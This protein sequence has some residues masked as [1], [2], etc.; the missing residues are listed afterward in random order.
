MRLPAPL[1]AALAAGLVATTTLANEPLGQASEALLEFHAESGLAVTVDSL[2]RLEAAG[3]SYQP[4]LTAPLQGL[5]EC[6][7]ATG[8]GL[9]AGV[10]R[11]DQA[12]AGVFGRT[13]D[14]LAA[15]EAIDEISRRHPAGGALDQVPP[16]DPALLRQFL[17]APQDPA[18]REALLGAVDART[19]EIYRS[20]ATDRALMA[21]EVD[22]LYGFLVEGL[23]LTLSLA[24]QERPTPLLQ[25]V[26]GVKAGGLA[27]LQ[28][29]FQAI[30]NDP[31]LADMVEL[32]NRD[33]L[34]HEVS[35]RVL[36]GR[37]A[38]SERDMAALLER[39]APVRAGWVAP[40]DDG[41]VG[42]R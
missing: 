11:F 30:R 12:Y 25:E 10:Y 19:A 26:L 32:A 35:E 27:R 23:Y 31:L 3:L 1:L 38:L 36:G 37:G 20:A 22:R 9:L 24:R 42:R 28:P 13:G 21:L 16:L 29:V 4:V 18:A 7:D 33:G 15:Q 2:D 17:E 5:L 6:R 39:I 40:C 41:A 14:Y 8:L 34:V